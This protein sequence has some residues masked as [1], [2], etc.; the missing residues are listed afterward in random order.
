MTGRIFI[1]LFTTLDGVAQAPG[2]PDEDPS[3]GFPYG[4]WQAPFPD[5]AIGAAVWQ[6]ISELDALLLGR[7]TYDIFAAYWPH[8]DGRI[9]EVFNRVP[10]Y[11]VSRGD[12]APGWEGTTRLGADVDAEVGAL[13]ERHDDIHVIGS[14]DLVQ[15]LLRERLFDV[16]TLWV[17]PVVLGQGK[18]VFP[19]GATPANMTLLEPALTGPRGVVQLRYGPADGTPATGTVEE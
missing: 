1:D 14:V 15:T 18:K 5:E 13:R 7:R 17:Y 11:V 9:A 2:G 19:D 12:L 6:G 8:Q 4:G 10:K 16:L 3:G